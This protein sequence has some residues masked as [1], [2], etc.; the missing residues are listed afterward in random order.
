MAITARILQWATAPNSRVSGVASEI[1]GFLAGSPVPA[2]VVNDLV[3][4]VTDWAKLAGE[5]FLAPLPAMDWQTTNATVTKPYGTF[6]VVI[7]AGATGVTFAETLFSLGPF[8][9]FG[10]QPVIKLTLSAFTPDNATFSFAAINP[11][12][13]VSLWSVFWE[14]DDGVG[15]IP[16]GN[17]SLSSGTG[18]IQPGAIGR[19]TYGESQG[20]GE[21]CTISSLI[22]ES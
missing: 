15:L 21:G 14:Q 18:A 1:V 22:L 5:R 3:G 4:R 12:T 2:G 6:Q 10:T 13:S 9:T 8:A 19:L 20:D 17:W 11:D 7:T 16:P